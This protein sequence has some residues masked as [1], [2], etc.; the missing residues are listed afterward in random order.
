MK[1]YLSNLF[2]FFVLAVLALPGTAWSKEDPVYTSFFSSAAAGGYD[3]TTYFIEGKPVKGTKSFKTEYMD[4]DWYFTSQE[5]LEK[6]VANPEM[7]A[8]QYGGYCAWALAQGDIASGDPL[9]W[10]V[11]QGKLYLNYDQEINDRWLGDKEKFIVDGDK[12]W[13]S[14][15]K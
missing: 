4:A 6:F 7:Y 5:N 1:L 10:T 11:Y 2:Y 13:P 12:N 8:P 3:V 9:L 14:V 15:L